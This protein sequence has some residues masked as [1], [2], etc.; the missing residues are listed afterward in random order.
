MLNKTLSGKRKCFVKAQ[1]NCK[2]AINVVG[3]GKKSPPEKFKYLVLRNCTSKITGHTTHFCKC[4]ATSNCTYKRRLH[5]PCYPS[6]NYCLRVLVG[7]FTQWCSQNNTYASATAKYCTKE[8]AQT[9]WTHVQVVDFEQNSNT[10]PTC[11][12]SFAH[13]AHKKTYLH[14]TN[15]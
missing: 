5:T 9:T 1:A 13:P 10:P 8:N 6:S 2:F 11:R 7:L 14:D 12:V 15:Y 4:T 3:I